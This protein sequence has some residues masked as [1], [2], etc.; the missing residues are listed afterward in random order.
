MTVKKY[1]LCSQVVKLVN[2]LLDASE[3]YWR[4]AVAFDAKAM[5]GFARWESMRMLRCLG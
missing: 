1:G 3:W 2:R 4:L 5:G